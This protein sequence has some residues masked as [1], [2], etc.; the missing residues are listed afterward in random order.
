MSNPPVSIVVI[1]KNGMPFI[2]RA[3][4]SLAEQD[5]SEF[6]VIIQDAASTDGTI[7]YLRSVKGMNLRIDSRPDKG[8]AH[9]YN[10]GFE[11]CRGKI[12]GTV[13]ADNWLEPSAISTALRVFEKRPDAAALYGNFNAVDEGGNFVKVFKFPPFDRMSLIVNTLVP[14]FG[15]S[16]F[17]REICGNALFSDEK[18]KHC[19]DFGIWLRLSDKTILKIDDV[20]CSVRSSPKSETCNIQF[21]DKFCFHKC[22]ILDDYLTRI[23]NEPLRKSLRRLGRSGIYCW[24]AE[25]ALILSGEG[26]DYRR[27]KNLAAREDPGNVRL[28]S[29]EHK[30]HN[31]SPPI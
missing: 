11:R 22:N 27:F 28:L 12:I 23:D 3:I 15:A 6:E 4:D 24:A 5:S 19:Q 10:L 18:I 8:Q 1:V 9:A 2:R 31:P 13:D 7:E 30:L 14:P 20:L 25:S 16:F 29:I 21:Y 26:D 17:N